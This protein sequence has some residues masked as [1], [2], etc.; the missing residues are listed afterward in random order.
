MDNWNKG[1]FD[2]KDAD[3]ERI[4]WYMIR[5][6]GVIPYPQIENTYIWVPEC[7]D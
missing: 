3:S 5:Y 1:D 4:H 7:K 6:L 2:R